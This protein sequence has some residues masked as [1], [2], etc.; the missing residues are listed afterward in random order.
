MNPSR[1]PSP[2]SCA[3]EGAPTIEVPLHALSPEALRG[4]IEEYVTRA[5]TDYGMREKAIEEKIADV[6]RQLECGEA[7]IVFDAEAQTTNIVRVV[8]A[9]T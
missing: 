2:T 8:E 9:N 1:S 7:V 5:G 4:V 3:D 6:Q